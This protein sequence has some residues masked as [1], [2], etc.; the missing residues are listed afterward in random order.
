[1]RSGGCV[2][3]KAWRTRNSNSTSTVTPAGSPL[4]GD[5]GCEG[6]SAGS[7]AAALAGSSPGPAEQLGRKRVSAETMGGAEATRPHDDNAALLLEE[8]LRELEERIRKL[9]ADKTSLAT[10]KANLEQKLAQAPVWVDEAFEMLKEA[11]F[12]FESLKPP[13]VRVKQDV[14]E[15]QL[16]FPPDLEAVYMHCGQRA[17]LTAG[18]LSCKTL[19]EGVDPAPLKE[20]LS[21]V[22]LLEARARS[23]A[24]EV[25]ARKNETR[26]D[27]SNKASTAPPDEN[28]GSGDSDSVQD[29]VA[30]EQE[31]GGAGV[32]PYLE[33]LDHERGDELET[34]LAAKKVK[35]CPG[36]DGADCPMRGRVVPMLRSG[37]NA[38]RCATCHMKWKASKN[39]KPAAGS[40]FDAPS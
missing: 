10:D 16:Q 29:S 32:F 33:Y 28:G 34:Q 9:E 18:R 15:P 35:R 11:Q 7:V 19:S 14:P 39:I 21:A 23:F 27:E 36:L 30:D 6:S 20:L 2:P 12:R 5:P 8:Q 37:S 26:W 3:K 31:Q 1:M 40:S 17:M 4:G 13:L 22:E 24:V 25:A 38:E